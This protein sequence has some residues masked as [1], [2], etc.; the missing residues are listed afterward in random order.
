MAHAFEESDLTMN[1]IS[2]L[3]SAPLDQD[4]CL[5]NLAEEVIASLAAQPAGTEPELVFAV[6]E[7][8][9]RQARRLI[10]PFLACLATKSASENGTPV[11]IYSGSLSFHRPGPDGTVWVVG[12]FSN[13]SGGQRLAIRRAISSAR[14]DSQTSNQTPIPTVEQ[15]H[16][17]ASPPERENKV[18]VQEKIIV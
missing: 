4:W 14:F 8:T 1:T 7:T 17:S 6:D 18:V 13:Q 12:D 15:R 5:D 3:L 16:A 10:R 11:N 9:N 2:D